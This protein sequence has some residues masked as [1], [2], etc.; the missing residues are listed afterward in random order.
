MP[1]PKCTAGR[2][3]TA[4]QVPDDDYD[5]IKY[6]IIAWPD[7]ISEVTNLLGRLDA[8]MWRNVARR[9]RL[10]AALG[11]LFLDERLQRPARTPTR[12]A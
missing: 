11:S 12:P 6:G 4:S 7:G 2:A 3:A 1:T 10:L 9:R 5:F 8:P